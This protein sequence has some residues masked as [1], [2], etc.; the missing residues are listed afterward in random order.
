MT[1]SD[2]QL[3]D[4]AEMD[5]QHFIR[6]LAAFRFFGSHLL[7]RVERSRAYYHSLPS[8]HH[9]LIREFEENLKKVEGCILHNNNLVGDIIQHSAPDIFNGEHAP[10]LNAASKPLNQ[11]NAKLDHAVY[12]GNKFGP[13]AFT[14]S[15]M[16]KVRSALKQF[17]R[18]WSVEGKAERDVCYQVVLNDVCELFDPKNCKSLD[19]SVMY[20]RFVPVSSKDLLNLL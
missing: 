1:G 3:R 8:S 5:R 13:F 12:P 10:E 16:D 17:V 19:L 14:N 18:D 15:D 20:E 2:E 9:K 11:S 7:K 6:T 4:A